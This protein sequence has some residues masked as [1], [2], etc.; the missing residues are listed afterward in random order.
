[1]A[2][3]ETL[4][5]FFIYGFV[6]WVLETTLAALRQR[7]YVD[8][9]LLFGPLCVIYGVGG[10]FLTGFLQDLRGEWFFLFLGCALWATVLEW[11]AGHFLEMVSHTRWWDY[12][13]RKWNL[14]GYICLSASLV[15]GLL[16][17][18]AV[19][20][21]SPLALRLV[22]MLPGR[23]GT[24]L[25]W[26]LL[27]ILAVDGLGTALTLA[28]IQRKMPQV[29]AMSNRLGA[30][31]MRLGRWI[32]GKTEARI[33]K[34]YP[35]ATFQWEWRK[36][37]AAVFAPG[38]GFY[39]IIWLFFLGAFLGDLTETV[40]CRLTMGVWMS[41]S[42]VVW[43][44]FSLVWGI[45]LALATKLLYRYKDKSVGFLFVAGTLLGGGYEYLCSVFT[46]VV[47]G[48]VFWD[49]SAHP[50]NLGGRINLLYCFFWGFAAVA[51]LRLLYPLFS[52]WIEKIPRR[53]GPALTW[54][55]ILFMSCNVVVSAAALARQGA[56]QMEIPPQNAWEEYL[57]ET[58]PDERLSII[59]PNAVQVEKSHRL[60]PEQG[61]A[62]T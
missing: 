31:T 58:Y 22:G 47:F 18:V 36:E 1:M 34:T 30:L 5:L 38:C 53:G 12:S 32:L 61:E 43:G 56:R 19:Q 46:E 24:V 23:V 11:V 2:I 35:E 21:G 37:K 44:P 4:W 27:A 10:V 16:G 54:V 8:R 60:S 62:A 26:V 55:M 28:G 40:F 33:Q 48:Q 50:F 51:W 6:G 52:R 41:R 49:Y 13:R 57:D 15:W 29:E 14:D 25:L 45:A 42:S 39:K 3:Q 59:Y 9:S 20:W 7:R 17:L